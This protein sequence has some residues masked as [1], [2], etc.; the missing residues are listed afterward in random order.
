MFFCVTVVGLVTLAIIGGPNIGMSFGQLALLNLGA[1]ITLFAMSGISFL[2]SCWFNRGKRSMSVGGGINM[3]FLVASMLGLFGS[4]VIPSVVRIDSLSFFNYCTII[5][6]FDEISILA[7]TAT[8]VWK[9]AILLAVGLVCYT[10]GGI[11]F[12]KKDLPL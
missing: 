10:I 4:K 3:F 7:G 1:F 12:R 11:K 2:A 9:L 6:L 5:S 8:F